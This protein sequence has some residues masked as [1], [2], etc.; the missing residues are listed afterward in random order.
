M[1]SIYTPSERRR[2]AALVWKGAR[3]AISGADPSRWDAQ[4]DRIDAAAEER[5]AREAAA[6][7][8]VLEKAKN[9]LAAAK[10]TER[11]TDRTGK[12]A[13]RQA[14]RDAEQ[15]LRRAEAAHRRFHR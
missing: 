9:D 12:A 13:A 5:G 7:A 1:P 3:Q 11:T 8:A 4:I 2:R 6:L 10:A 14:R 15:Q